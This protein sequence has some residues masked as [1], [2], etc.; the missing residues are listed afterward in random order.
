MKKVQKR[1]GFFQVFKIGTFLLLL[2]AVIFST[3]SGYAGEW[4][5][6]YRYPREYR[7]HVEQYSS[8]YGVEPNLIYAIIKA[9]S[10]FSSSAVSRVGAIG[11]MQ[12]M[13]ETYMLD[14]KE[15]IGFEAESDVLFDPEKNIQAG[16]YYIAHWYAYFGTSVEAIASYNAGIGNVQKW[17]EAGYVDDSG[18]LDIEKIPFSETRAYVKRVL[19]Y[20]DK[21]DALY[22][23]IAD[24]GRPIHENIC[25]E[26][27]LAYGKEY[28]I[29]SRLIMAI[30]RAE[31]T[32]DPSCLSHVGAR[33]LM[34]IMKETYES[35]IQAALSL[36]EDHEALSN[37]KLNVRCGVYYL[38]WL[39]E[40]LDG[41]EQIVAAYNGGI[42]NVKRWLKDSRYSA[43]G[44]VLIVENIPSDGVKTYVKRVMTYYKEYCTR[45]RR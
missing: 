42:G 29:D 12:I 21:Y 27:A 35:D 26:W 15:K 13:P 44:E 41:T 4:L 31:S 43:D 25:H 10:G 39:S 23:H 8:L 19:E 37:G 45:Y 1:K 17:I 30:I 7:A 34:Q 14:I 22:G 38:H 24:R 18:V 28:E 11:L 36:E 20:K 16:T 6:A 40:R 32:F 2:F 9:E 33:G 3:S 5:E